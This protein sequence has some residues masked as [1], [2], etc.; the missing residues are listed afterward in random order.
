MS[1]SSYFREKELVDEAKRAANDEI[2][3]LDVHV[4]PYV[5][6]RIVEVVRAVLAGH[7]VPPALAPPEDDFIDLPSEEEDAA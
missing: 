4:T 3:R 5:V 1:S 2:R 6:G 7:P